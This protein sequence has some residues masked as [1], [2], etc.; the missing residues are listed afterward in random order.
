MESI[1]TDQENTSAQ[2]A[3]MMDILYKDVYRIDSYIAQ[4][5]NGT[6]RSVKTQE[7]SSQGSSRAAEASVKVLYGPFSQRPYLC[8]DGRTDI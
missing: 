2:E 5:I 6:L 8:A 7:T 4:L 3:Q 1:Y